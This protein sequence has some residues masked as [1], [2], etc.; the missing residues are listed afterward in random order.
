METYNNARFITDGHILSPPSV[1]GRG[2]VSVKLSLSKTVRDMRALDTSYLNAVHALQERYIVEVLVMHAC[3]MGKTAKELGMHRNTLTR[4]LREL[5]IDVRRLRDAIR[6]AY[7][8][9]GREATASF[10]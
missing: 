7:G 10:S 2:I 6:S 9:P 8:Q 3:H 4:T 1:S 5:D